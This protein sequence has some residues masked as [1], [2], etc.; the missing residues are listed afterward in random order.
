M[1]NWPIIGVLVFKLTD[2][3]PE[4]V[5]FAE[6]M[7]IRC[8]K[9]LYIEKIPSDSDSTWKIIWKWYLTSIGLFEITYLLI[10]PIFMRVVGGLGW[11]IALSCGVSIS[12]EFSR[13]IR[14]WMWFWGEMR[15]LTSQHSINMSK[16]V[17]EWSISCWVSISNDFLRTIQMW[18]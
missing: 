11:E 4:V 13:R 15:S 2:Y 7:V 8:G 14:L 16:W 5:N 18:R 1:V 17:K 12:Y 6:I 9:K 10:L 3:L